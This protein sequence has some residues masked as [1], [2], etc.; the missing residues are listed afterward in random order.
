M[1][2]DNFNEEINSE[3]SSEQNN[4]L[5]PIS[6]MY[7]DWFLEYASYVILDRAVPYVEDGLKPVQRRILHAMKEMD[8]G[9]FNKVA[10]IIGQTMQYHPHGDA[11]IG[12]ALIN[13]GQKGLLIE[14][15]GNWGNVLTGD[16]PAAPRYIE[17][18]LSEFAKEVVFNNKTTEWKIAYDGR[19]KEP[20]R[21][22]VKFPLLLAQGVEGIAVGL[23]TRILPHNFNE[24]LDACIA[25]M[26]E[27]DFALYPDF[28]TGGMIDVTNY[29]QGE[30]GGRLR[31]RA[32]L[33]QED[34]RTIKITDLP[35]GITTSGLIDSIL[36]AN[37][38]GK[39]KVKKVDDNTSKEVEILV[40]LPQGV[41]P[42][43]AINAL[44]AFT[45][46]E[47]SVSPNCCV[48][49]DDKPQFLSVKD[50]LRTAADHTLELLQQE[51]NIKKSE[52]LEQWH[53]ASLEK[54]FIEQRIY[55][56]IEESETWESIISTIREGLKPH[57]GNLV[58]E[59]TDD[60]ITRLTEI[61]I[62]R[63]SKYDEDR[64]RD[65]IKKI[66]NELE[67]VQH[68]LDHIVD[69]T[70]DYFKN[71]KK[72]YGK[73]WPRRTE[74]RRFDEIEANVVAVANQK[75]YVDRENGFIGTNLKKSESEYIG[76][77]SDLDDVI[78][79]RRDGKMMV[80][81]VAPKA[82]VGTDIIYA[83]IFYRNDERR[84][85]HMIYRKNKKGR[86]MIK[87]FQVLGITRD[88]EYTL[89]HGGKDAEVVY[90]SVQPNGER[91]KVRVHLK[92]KLR[93]KKTSFDFDFGD[94]HIRSRSAQGNVLCDHDIRRVEHLEQG[95]S[96]LGG[97]DI[98]FDHD[99][100]RL[101]RE[102]K[103]Q[104]LGSF[105]TGDKIIAF[106]D[107]GSY[108]LT[109]FELTNRYDVKGNLLHIAKLHPNTI[110]SAVYKDGKSGNFYIK[111]FEIET[112]MLDRKNV[113]VTEHSKSELL[114]VTTKLEP[115]VNLRTSTGKKIEMDLYEEVKVKGWKALGNKLGHKV[116]SVELLEGYDPEESEDTAEETE[117]DENP[118]EEEG[119]KPLFEE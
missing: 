102:G 61:R 19:K 76:E 78:I 112:S 52:L 58:R 104:Y 57:I 86:H 69:Y 115:I 30:R 36:K 105:D 41:D 108:E 73:Q 48:I 84:V 22:P 53:F 7:E 89:A 8:D 97:I 93:M 2:D 111:R 21:L 103:G 25:H 116:K 79:F 119:Q 1:S 27:Q 44:Y 34:K 100:Q 72:K 88:K 96:T 92:P 42:D 6:G 70:I 83:D 110:V 3:E 9:R 77:C 17:A 51:L 63:I 68:N 82:Y 49:I 50:V 113:F 114:W 67:Q 10:N 91:E 14:T 90:F 47:V 87:R 117:E 59:V 38:K 18:R 55:R 64:A 35:H 33:K 118:D 13:L 60:D 66:E 81:K 29:Q 32:T 12:D 74:I 40:H 39:I 71:L 85:Y 28:Q 80:T 56:Q 101:N 4:G 16:S 11:A 37:D 15:Q 26:K 43:Q 94:L 75:L 23:S 24:L 109:D 106:Y 62:K 107:D 45:D 31:I 95:K 98:W 20:E 46:C 54:I 99:T 5:K 65:N